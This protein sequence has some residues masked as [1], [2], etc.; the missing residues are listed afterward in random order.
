MKVLENY[1]YNDTENVF[2]REPMVVLIRDLTSD[3]M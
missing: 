2:E 1:T 3:R